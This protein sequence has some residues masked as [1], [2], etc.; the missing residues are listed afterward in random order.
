MTNKFPYFLV[1]DD[2]ALSNRI[3]EFLITSKAVF[4]SA[5]IQCFT[6]PEEGLEY[7]KHHYVKANAPLTILLLDINMPAINGWEF[8]EIFGDLDV[9]IKEHIKI[10]IFSSSVNVRDKEIAG[11]NKHVIDYIVKPLT[12]EKVKNIA[13]RFYQL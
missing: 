6:I 12:K 9:S 4:A 5:T 7:I 2:D 1:I 8:L 13:N 10:Y 11:L 3:C